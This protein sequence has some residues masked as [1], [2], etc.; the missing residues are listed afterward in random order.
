MTN[1]VKYTIIIKNRDNGDTATL[2][3]AYPVSMAGPY[4]PD[5]EAKA[6]KLFTMTNITRGWNTS[7]ENCDVSIHEGHWIGFPNS[8]ID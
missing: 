4:K 7:Y 6:H 2:Q 5:F 8:S 1:A 3:E